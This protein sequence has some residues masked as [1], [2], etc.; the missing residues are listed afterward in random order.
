MTL[1]VIP[2]L[3]FFTCVFNTLMTI[4]ISYWWKYA[5]QVMILYQFVTQQGRFNQCLFLKAFYTPCLMLM[6]NSYLWMFFNTLYHGLYYTKPCNEIQ[7]NTVV[8]SRKYDV[9]NV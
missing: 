7:E 3:C 5:S 9:N 2:S 8:S 1:R 6:Q 4:S